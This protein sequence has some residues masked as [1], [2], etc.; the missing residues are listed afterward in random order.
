[1]ENKGSPACCFLRLGSLLRENS[2]FYKLRI[3]SLVIVNGCHLYL[4]A[5]ES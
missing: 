5:E 4:Q 2:H 1:M 3:R